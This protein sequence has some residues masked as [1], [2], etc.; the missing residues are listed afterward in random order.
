[1]SSSGDIMMWVAEAMDSA[2]ATGY[3]FFG[4]EFI[5]IVLLKSVLRLRSQSSRALWRKSSA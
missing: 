2:H 4:I 3:T 5:G 1:M